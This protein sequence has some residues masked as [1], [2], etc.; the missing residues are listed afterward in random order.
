MSLNGSAVRVVVIGQDPEGRLSQPARGDRAAI[1]PDG[2]LHTGDIALIDEHDGV[3]TVDRVKGADQV[4]GLR[5]P[6]A[7]RR[8]RG[9]RWAPAMRWLRRTPWAP[10]R[11]PRRELRSRP[12]R[13]VGEE[14]R[15]ELDRDDLVAPH[16][17]GHG[18]LCPRRRRGARPRGLSRGQLHW[19]RRDR[20]PTP[21]GFGVISDGVNAPAAAGSR[22]AVRRPRWG[23][24]DRPAT[25]AGPAAPR[26]ARGRSARGAEPC[27]T[28]SWGSRR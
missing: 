26:S 16:G 5:A 10:R 23:R 4:Q 27:L 17:R 8:T 14:H 6:R 3:G 18:C 9:S 21:R 11:P 15:L 25:D 2:W 1:D 19:W 12:D 13:G 20:A 7:R 22:S 24:P 28:A